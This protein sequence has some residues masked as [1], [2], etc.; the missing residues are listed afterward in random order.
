MS[1]TNEEPEFLWDVQRSGGDDKPPRQEWTSWDMALA[2][3][4]IC[5]GIGLLKELLC[6]H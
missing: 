4:A 3:I 5:L 1:D 2:V 6:H